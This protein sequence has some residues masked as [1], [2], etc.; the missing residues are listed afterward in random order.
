MKPSTLLALI[1]LSSTALACMHLKGFFDLTCVNGN[2]YYEA[3]DDGRKVCSGDC[4]EFSDC[5][6]SC[7]PG[8][9]LKLSLGY[10][11]MDYNTPHGSWGFRIYPD[12]HY[13]CCLQ[14]SPG[15]CSSHGVHSE[16][17]AWYFC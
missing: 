8:Y 14:L 4:H 16:L 7:E 9:S 2:G 17:D 11:H 12:E 5:E 1:P 15:V 13:T 10:S 3:T 6:L